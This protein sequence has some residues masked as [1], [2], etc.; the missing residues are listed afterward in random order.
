[1]LKKAL[2]VFDAT[3]TYRIYWNLYGGSPAIAKS[4]YVY[5]SIIITIILLPATIEGDSGFIWSSLAFEIIPSMLGFS[6]G[7]MAIVIAFSQS[8]SFSA[9]TQDGRDD[10][11]YMK[12]IANFFHFIFIQTITILIAFFD[13]AYSIPFISVIGSFF[14]VYGVLVA[15]A[16]AG[17]LLNTA[18][19]FN[20]MSTRSS[21]E[22]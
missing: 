2:Y 1:L 17:M 11:L 12:I 4:P 3:A 6:M 18:R 22:N 19:I 21:N 7:G 13:T 20:R 5:A 8:Q 14:L 15:L 9:M 10:S 16:T